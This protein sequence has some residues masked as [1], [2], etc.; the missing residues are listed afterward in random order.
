MAYVI[1]TEA[2]IQQKSG[3]GV[4]VVYDTTCMENAELRAIALLNVITRHNWVDNEPTSEDVKAVLSDFISSF[5]AIEAISYN[6]A[7]YTDLIEAENMITVLRD[8]LLRNM[9]IL[10]DKKT[11][12]FITEHAT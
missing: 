2:E 9:S 5:V 1:T 8:S 10:R 7:G 12:T 4:S 11:V 3:A 6:M